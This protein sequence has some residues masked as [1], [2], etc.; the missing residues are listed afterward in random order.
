MSVVTTLS[1]IIGE[2][3]TQIGKGS[4]SNVFKTEYGHALKIIKNPMKHEDYISEVAILKYLNHPNII[5]LTGIQLEPPQYS[6]Q[7]CNGSLNTLLIS[8]VNE[9]RW[10]FHQILS[11]L[12]YCHKYR[13]WH[14]DIKPA[15]ILYTLDKNGNKNIIIS[16]FNISKIHFLKFESYSTNVVSLWWRP[17]ELLLGDSQY[18]GSLVDIWSTGVILIDKIFKTFMFMAHDKISQIKRIFKILGVPSEKNW[19]GVTDLP[20]WSSEY[21]NIRKYKWLIS[22]IKY[23]NKKYYNKRTGISNGLIIYHLIIYFF[24]I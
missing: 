3:I 21:E 17:P 19:S 8:N 2:N 18:D 6:M 16:D 12:E 24:K 11:G 22:D 14:L 1:T 10:I 23:K 15:N 4:F 20:N 13:V 9:R 5:K 7:Y